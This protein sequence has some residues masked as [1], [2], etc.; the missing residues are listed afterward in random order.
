MGKW[1]DSLSKRPGGEQFSNKIDGILRS[2]NPRS[3][4]PHDVVVIQC[5]EEEDLRMQY[6]KLLRVFLRKTIEIYSIPR[7][8]YS[9]ILIKSLE[10]FPKSTTPQKNSLQKIQTKT[11]NQKNKKKLGIRELT[12]YCSNSHCQGFHCTFTCKQKKTGNGK[13]K[14]HKDEG[15]QRWRGEIGTNSSI[16]SSGI[17]LLKIQAIWIFPLVAIH[18]RKCRCEKYE[19]ECRRRRPSSQHHR[20]RR[21]RSWWTNGKRKSV[22]AHQTINR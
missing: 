12:L 19:S 22:F 1:G 8:F 2:I 15:T 17:T 11:E 20:R 16:S 9:F 21:D 13:T 5:L 6:L 4:E 7:N 14:E 18:L 10:S 3:V